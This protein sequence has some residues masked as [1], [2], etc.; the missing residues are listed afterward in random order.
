[1][2]FSR[3]IVDQLFDERLL[4]PIYYGRPGARGRTQKAVDRDELATLVAKLHANATRADDVADDLVPISKAAEKAKVPA[5][6]VVHMVLGGFLDRVFR[7]PGGGVA[8][9]RV[10]PTEVKRHSAYCTRGLSPAEAFG[11]LKIPREVGWCLADRFPHE[12]SLAVE[13]IACPRRNHQ[14]PRFDQATVSS[15][16]ARFVHPARLAEQHDLQVGEVVSHLKRL[17]VKP[18][19]CRAEIGVDFFRAGDLMEDL[20]R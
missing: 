19:L 8:A 14:I 7:V 13:W 16:L 3:P 18:A 11:Y 10:D 17:G 4:N 2:E 15:F 6:T 9:L 1:M 5:V 20:R 12:V